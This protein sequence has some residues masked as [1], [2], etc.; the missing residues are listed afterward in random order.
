MR[1]LAKYLFILLIPIV[2]TTASAYEHDRGPI[3]PDVYGDTPPL[4]AEPV[5]TIDLTAEQPDLR[6]QNPREKISVR[7]SVNSQKLP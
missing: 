7:I 2:S 6:F 1:N 4:F 5:I 3:V